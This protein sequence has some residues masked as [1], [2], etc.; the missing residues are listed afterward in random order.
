MFHMLE[1]NKVTDRRLNELEEVLSAGIS[2]W[3]QDG[4]V[5]ST[6]HQMAA[7]TGSFPPTLAN[8]LI[9]NFS[10]PGDVVLDLFAGKGTT[11]LEA[12]LLSRRALGCD[13]SEEAF[14]L[15]KAKAK[16]VSRSLA[17]K[18][19]RWKEVAVKNRSRKIDLRRV[20][21]SV[22][23]F[24]HPHT[25]RQILAAFEILNSDRQDGSSIEK[26]LAFHALGCLIGII[27][28]PSGG[29]LSIRCSHAYSMSP[30]YV[31]KYVSEH[32]KKHPG[33]RTFERPRRNVIDRLLRKSD[34]VALDPHTVASLSTRG[35]DAF[36]IEA[37]A[38]DPYR[39]RANTIDLIVTSPPYLT[40]QTY[41]WDNWLRLWFLG[42]K[43]QTVQKEMRLLTVDESIYKQE[44]RSVFRKMFDVLKPG[45]LA[46]VIVGDVKKYRKK[47]P[48]PVVRIV[49]LAELLE[50]DAESVGFVI[51]KVVN[52]AIPRA[53]RSTYT[54]HDGRA[55]TL[56]DRIL[57]LQKPCRI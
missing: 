48:K 54:F 55:G 40:A 45:G 47:K 31:R 49:N 13:L 21:D 28:G 46:F 23:Q 51:K 38:F 3:H 19:I 44:M 56:V 42:H 6:L 39:N 10:K 43:Y 52:D 5:P 36:W 12:I 16:P 29:F 33:D 4:F 53:R 15:S 22:R 57:C 17:N 18:Y 9:K 35:C 26:K 37:K 41:P 50:D 14:I 20:P 30:K 7:R 34:Q 27:H 24:Y 25:L 32:E 8:Y 2:P 11:L 1:G